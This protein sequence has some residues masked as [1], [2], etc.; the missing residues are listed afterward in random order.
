MTTADYP[1]FAM[2]A[3]K[4][5]TMLSNNFKRTKKTIDRWL[6]R[7]RSLLLVGCLVAAGLLFLGFASYS[8]NSEVVFSGSSEETA[9]AQEPTSEEE[10]VNVYLCGYVEN[11]GV[12]AL[13]KGSRLSDALELAGGFS[14]GAQ[15]EAVNLARVLNDGEQIVVPS[16]AGAA[17][18]SIDV[19]SSSG[20]VNINIATTE[21]LQSLQG[22][23]PS[24]AQKII[25]F[26]T[27]NGMFSSID[28][29]LFVSGIGEKKLESLRPYITVG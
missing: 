3:G 8:N 22:V 28:D 1:F 21:E 15:K 13:K 14:E 29:L 10:L 6:D 11:P 7:N 18:Q 19:G 23:G 24:T 4:E 20:L 9:L 27:N 25:A 12:Y 26:R 16:Q 2:L 5:S 17:S